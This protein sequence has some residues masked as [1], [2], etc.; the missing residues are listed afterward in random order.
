[1]N[2]RTLVALATDDSYFNDWMLDL[3]SMERIASVCCDESL[4]RGVRETY[5]NILLRP[6]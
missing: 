3:Y 4:W 5:A 6:N 2:E 1:M